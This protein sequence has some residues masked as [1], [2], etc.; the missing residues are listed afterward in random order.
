MTVLVLAREFD[1][2]ADAVVKILAD[3]R[4]P[5]FRADLSEFPTRLRLDAHL[6]RAGRLTGRL[7][8]D[9]RSVRLENIR[10]VW[11]R[12]PST[13]VLAPE[14]SGQERE[15][16]YREANSRSAASSLRS[17]WCGRTIRTGARTRYGSRISG[18]SPRRC[19]G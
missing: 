2:T 15:F 12:N 1:P 9:H 5:A 16:A 3:R 8:N 13:Y 11:N 19:A 14:L 17:T 10:S 18:N 6:D 4:V 7:W